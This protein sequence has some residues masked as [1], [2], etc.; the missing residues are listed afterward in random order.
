MASSASRLSKAAPRRIVVGISGATGAVYGVT[1]LRLLGGLGVE[2]HLVISKFGRQ[3]IEWETPHSVAEVE[4]MA[5]KHYGNGNLAAPIS[6]GSYPVDGMLVAPCSVTTLSGI[7]NSY[8]ETLIVRAADVCLKERRPLVLMVR[9]APLHL[10][11]LRLMA[12]V[13]EMGGIILPPVPSF[14]HRPKSIDD[15]VSATVARSFDALGLS[16]SLGPRWGEGDLVPAALARN[17]STANGRN[18][19]DEHHRRTNAT[20]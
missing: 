19:S 7:A 3:C 20:G 15:L 17:E 9:E 13:A 14:Y 11:H 12:R 10:G 5:S 6:S 4:S 2:T 18:T 16:H 8:D 1:A